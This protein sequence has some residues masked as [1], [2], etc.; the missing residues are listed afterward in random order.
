MQLYEDAELARKNL[1]SRLS[2]LV[3]RRHVA[4]GD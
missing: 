1:E 3:T 4:N 2:V